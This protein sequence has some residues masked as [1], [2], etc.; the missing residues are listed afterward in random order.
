MGW[1]RSMCPRQVHPED[2][3]MEQKQPGRHQ[4]GKWLT[5]VWVLPGGRTR[6]AQNLPGTV[7]RAY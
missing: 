3:L 1:A 5:F 7:P 2:R 4:I 6:T